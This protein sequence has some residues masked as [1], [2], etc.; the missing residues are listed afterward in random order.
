MNITIQKITEGHSTA[1]SQ[2]KNEHM[3][4][5]LLIV[6]EKKNFLYETVNSG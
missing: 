1:A 5:Y 6:K 4:P 3:H 2:T